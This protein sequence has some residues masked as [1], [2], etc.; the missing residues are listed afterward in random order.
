M[1]QDSADDLNAN[2]VCNA[3]G[4]FLTLLTIATASDFNE[5]LVG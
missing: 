2:E 5:E 1:K 3:S 4:E